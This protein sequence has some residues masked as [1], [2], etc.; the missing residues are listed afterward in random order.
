MGIRTVETAFRSNPLDLARQ[1]LNLNR[2]DCTL[3]SR[4]TSARLGLTLLFESVFGG[5]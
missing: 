4:F 5:K 1:N 2:T 3:F